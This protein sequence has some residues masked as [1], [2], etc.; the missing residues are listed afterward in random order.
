MNQVKSLLTDTQKSTLSY[1]INSI[2]SSNKIRQRYI[3]TRRVYICR[4]LL[5]SISLNQP[6]IYVYRSLG[7][8]TRIQMLRILAY[9]IDYIPGYNFDKKY[10]SDI[11]GEDIVDCFFF[12]L[13]KYSNFYLQ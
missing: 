12:M 9:V 13:N 5:R 8:K 7:E 6:F 3:L 2:I 10:A 1:A 4:L 11:Y